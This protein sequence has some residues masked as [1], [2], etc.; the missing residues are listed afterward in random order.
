MSDAYVYQ[1]I[2]DNKL[3]GKSLTNWSRAD[4]MVLLLG[5]ASTVAVWVWLSPILAF[6]VASIAVALIYRFAT[7]YGRGYNEILAAFHGL[8]IEYMLHGVVYDANDFA[9]GEERTRGLAAFLRRHDIGVDGHSPLPFDFVRVRARGT[10]FTVLRSRDTPYD[11]IVIAASGGAFAGRDP[12]AQQAAVNALAETTNHTIAKSDLK[13]GISY[14]L[15]NG[16]L[17]SAKLQHALKEMIDPVIAVP[18]MF[19]LDEEELAYVTRR[20]QYADHVLKTTRY[21]GAAETWHAVVLSIRRTYEWERAARGKVSGKDLY[22][23]P[24]ADLARS[25]VQSLQSSSKLELGDVRCL[26]ITE[27]SSLVRCSWDA[28]DI[29]GY[30]KA[31]QAGEIPTTDEE[32]DALQL[33]QKGTKPSINLLRP[34]PEQRVTVHG[35]KGYVQFDNN[36]IAVVRVTQ[37][38]ERIRADEFK[39]L[40]AIMPAGTWVRQAMVGSSVSGGAETTQYILGQ[41]AMLNLTKAFKGNR[42]V[43]DPR[44][45]RKQKAL[46]DQANQLSV[47]SVSQHFN[48]LFA[49]V[50]TDPDTLQNN[51]SD[52]RA[53]L[54]T[55]GFKT[56]NVKATAR[57]V[58]AVISATLGINRL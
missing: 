5:V 15:L 45:K 50:A 11:H 22:E 10:S 21:A 1:E 16:P 34:F 6:F 17:N 48:M 53:A 44:D 36:F 9:T 52:L 28:A 39:S 38:P 30:Y 49:I 37:L 14:L 56:D 26:G 3:S 31:Q 4:V 55:R 18:D 8:Y 57:L 7:S 13:V 29:N 58:P 23:L 12:N 32:L 2:P 35:K 51:I 24:L 47:H 19:Y 20:R 33:R 25:M 40:H 27:L 41:S 42:I 54:L 46:A 43:A